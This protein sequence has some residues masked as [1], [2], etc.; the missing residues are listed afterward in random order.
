MQAGSLR[1]LMI[2]GL[3]YALRILI[4]SPGFTIIAV[5]AI[6]LGIGAS[7]VSFSI[8]N[9]VLLRPFPW[10]TDSALQLLASLE[11]AVLAVFIVVR[12]PSLRVALARCRTTPFL[13][14]CWVLTGM[15]AATFS[16]FANFGL[17]VRQRSLVLPALF[18]LLAV[19]ARLAAAS[20]EEPEPRRDEQ[21]PLV[22]G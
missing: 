8:V 13:L 3:T 4:K 17:L 5:L 1:Y 21:E 18:V 20:R 19:D 11:S 6:A 2:R 10:E 9:A 12:L 14:Y 22:L 16:S 7:T 15:Y